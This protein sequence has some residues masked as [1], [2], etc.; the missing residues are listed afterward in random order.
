MLNFR[1]R[2]IFAILFSIILNSL[3]A[4][5]SRLEIL[6]A[7]SA[8][9]IKYK[10]AEVTKLIGDVQ[11]KQEGTF[12]N[13]DSA[14]FFGLENR[15]EAFSNVSIRHN[16]TITIL[17]KYLNYD[18]N[19]KKAFIN[20]EVVL[21]DKSMTL[22][23][24][25]LDYDLNNQ[26]GFYT[27]FGK[28]VSGQNTLTSKNGYYYA[29]TRDFFF[30]GNVLL[31]NPDYT[32]K[33]DTL[34]YN[35]GSKTAFFYGAT[36][37][38]GKTDRIVC[39]N[40]WYNTSTDQ[41][42]FSRNAVLYS[43]KKM[44]KADSLFYDKKNQLGKAYRNIFIYDST[45]KVILVG[46]YGQMNG[47]TKQTFVTKKSYAIKLIDANDSLFLYADTLALFQKIK[48]QKEVMKAY[49]QVKVF[50]NNLQAVCDSLVYTSFDSSIWMYS[51]PILWSGKNQIT[52]DTIRFY[53]N[54]NRLDSF[55]LLSDAFL[56]SKEKGAHFNQIKGREMVGQ[57]DSSK[58]K[59]L[60]VSGNGQSIYYAKEDSLHYIGIN[61][62]DCSEMKFGFLSGELQN[63]IFITNP[64]ATMYPLDEL[65][66]ED[67]RLKG[68]KWLDL[69]RPQRANYQ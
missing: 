27:N 42:Q 45:Q 67:L 1:L 40:G 43:D 63:A 48:N 2:L 24:E 23:S 30:K 28:I 47:K 9:I 56:I 13:C 3:F 34:L 20:G 37:I 8:E 21:S 6:F 35:T 11:M 29:R 25:Q 60:F 32:M 14:L 12:L 39:E 31:V 38:D 10:N 18:G 54:N 51:K 69:R 66:P 5:N 49:R 68:F 22:N 44:L 19:S 64:E 55:K 26:Y 36:Q 46:A 61:V 58:I 16:D 57:L 65:K 41:S 33:S 15:V 4:Q 50:K 59:S 52:S 62:I 17:G 53:V 7:K